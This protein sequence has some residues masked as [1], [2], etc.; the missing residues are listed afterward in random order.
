LYDKAKQLAAKGSLWAG[1]LDR[2]D[3]LTRLEV[4]LRGA[5]VPFKKIRNLHRYADVDLL[6]SV[7]F[8]KLKKL[9]A[10]RKPLHGLAAGHLEHLISQYGLHATKKRFSAPQWAYIEKLF[11]RHA[12]RNEVPDIR[13]HMKKS[14][15]DWL[16]DRI[17]FPRGQ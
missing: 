5:G 16:N 10:G 3:E 1:M 8:R 13:A 9:Q 12:Q 6:A 14:I 4:Q 7:E 2:N 15:R 11:F 17:R